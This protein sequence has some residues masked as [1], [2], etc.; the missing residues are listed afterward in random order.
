MPGF[1]IDFQTALTR[2]AKYMLEGSTVGFA[3]FWIPQNRPNLEEVLLISVV[4]AATFALIDMF[5]HQADRLQGFG[6]GHYGD[7]MR[8]SIRQGT[9]FSMGTQLTGG[10]K[11]FPGK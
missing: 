8:R 11:G 5:T 4:A 10:L 6:D 2:L 7:D 3:S 1:R 9:G